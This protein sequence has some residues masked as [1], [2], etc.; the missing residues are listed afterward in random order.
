MEKTLE[1]TV[2]AAETPEDFEAVRGLFR[3][4]AEFMGFELCF[5]GF[6]KEM[7]GLPGAY[8]P[9]LGE[10]LLCRV[11]GAPSGCVATCRYLPGM[12]EMKRLYVRPEFR[13]LKIGRNL[14]WLIMGMAREAGHDSI[15][16]ETVPDTM[17]RAVALYGKLGFEKASCPGGTDPR[18]TCYTRTLENLA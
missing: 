3:E 13:D 12:A 4:Y 7:E 5:Q 15:R 8:A 17:P 6:D 9:P 11:G 1:I 16:L 14:A 18:I 10:L 2:A